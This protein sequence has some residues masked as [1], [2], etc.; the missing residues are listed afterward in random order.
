MVKKMEKG[1]R[2]MKKETN[3]FGKSGFSGRFS[4]G[5]DFGVETLLSQECLELK[6]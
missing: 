2:Y 3:R 5:G 6:K 1:I 4:S